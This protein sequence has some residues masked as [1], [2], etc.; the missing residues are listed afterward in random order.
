MSEILI[1]EE[2]TTH[3]SKEK[4]RGD[5]ES[6]PFNDQGLINP[7]HLDDL[8]ADI[9][10]QILTWYVEEK[11]SRQMVIL[12]RKLGYD[13]SHLRLWRW[14]KTKFRCVSDNGVPS[15][16]MEEIRLELERKVIYG[17]LDIATETVRKMTA[18]EVKSAKDFDAMASAI[19]KLVTAMA[20][21]ERVEY[22]KGEAIKK[23]KETLKAEFQRIMAGKPE[24]VEQVQEILEEAAKRITA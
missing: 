14:C 13:I 8:P 12:L 10:D 9:Q 11:P 15:V 23:V 5:L 1:T 4:G 17:M 6:A 21:R 22:E 16:N 24:L 20:S 2:V 18:P 19:A 7:A 3:E